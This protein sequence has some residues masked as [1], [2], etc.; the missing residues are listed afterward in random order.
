M[1]PRQPKPLRSD[2]ESELTR[3][4]WVVLICR[5]LEAVTALEVIAQ[6]AQCAHLQLGIIS[7]KYRSC[8]TFLLGHRTATGERVPV[9]ERPIRRLAF[10]PLENLR[11]YNVARKRKREAERAT[12]LATARLRGLIAHRSLIGAQA[13]SYGGAAYFSTPPALQTDWR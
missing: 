12:D 2:A 8:P 1:P 7:H 3:S 6:K 5:T 10:A 11:V 4:A 9:P 13:T